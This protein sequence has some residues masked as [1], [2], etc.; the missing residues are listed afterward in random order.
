[1]RTWMTGL[2][3]ATALVMAG[4][5]GA[6]ARP[7]AS[8]LEAAF[9]SAR[10]VSPVP[11]S[12][13]REQADWREYGDH[14]AEGLAV[15]LTDLIERAARDRAAWGLRTTIAEL[16]EACLPIVLRDCHAVSGG[17]V[18]QRDG[19]TLYWQV[20]RGFTEADGVGGGFV[21][22]QPEADGTALR[23]VAW[24]YGGYVYG[25]PEWVV[26][27]DV[28]GAVHVAVPGVH[29]GTGA[30]N[31]DVV[32]RLAGADRP[33]VQIDNFSWRDDLDD[34][35]PPGLEVWKGVNFVYDSLT[36]ATSLWRTGDANCC[37]TGGEAFLDFGIRDD[38]LILTGVQVN[39]ALAALARQIPAD[40]FAWVQRNMACAHWSGEEPYDA[41]RAA[42]IEAALSD[43]RCDALEA[44]E[45]ALR[46]THADDEAVLGI[47]A[48]APAM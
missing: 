6:D 37:P 2:A 25:Q 11:L 7:A 24:D 5:G 41:G 42:R 33:L 20:Q 44:D 21:L 8:D 29:G 15:R 23:P 13:D 9:Q 36:A 39:D 17:Y 27:S 35:L 28:E 32:F 18:S 46:R 43:A 40:V 34:W 22:L 10:A 14:S 47:L 1:M 31:A 45:Q 16:A 48:R 3:A 4:A 38:R 12:L 30:H 19:P 26:G